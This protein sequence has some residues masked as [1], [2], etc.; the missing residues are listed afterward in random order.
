MKTNR[1]PPL[2]CSLLV[3]ALAA[4]LAARGKALLLDFGPTATQAAYAT[5]DPAHWLGAVPAS[6]ITWNTTTRDTNTVYYSDGATATGLSLELGRSAAGVDIINFSDNGF[7]SSALG[8]SQN[9]GVYAGSSPVRDAIF[10]GSGGANN[11]AVGLRVNGLPAGTYTLFVHGRNTSTA[12]A[13]PLLFYA[14]NRASAD[15]YTFSINDVLAALSN[16]SPAITNGFNE[17]NNYGVLTVSLAAGESLYI[18]SEGTVSGEARGF[19]NAIVIYFGVPQLPARVTSQPLNKSVYEGVTMTFNAGV[20]GNPKP[21]YQWHFNGTDTLVDGPGIS[22]ATTDKLTLHKVTPAMAGDYSLAVTNALGW[23]ASSNATLMVSSPFNTAQMTNTW[24]LLPGERPYLGIGGTERSMAY[25]P[26]NGNL[27]L[28]SRAAADPSIVVLDG[29]NGAEKHLMNV[30][31]IPSTTPNASVGLSTIGVADDGVVFG[32][33]V[34]VGATTAA[35]NIYG[36]PDDTADYQPSLVFAGDPAASVQPNLRWGDNFAVRGAGADTQILMAPTTGTNVALLRTTSGQNFQ[37][38]IPPAIIAV[39][40]VPSGFARWSIAFGPGTNTFWAKTSGGALFLVEFNV[41]AGTGIVTHSYSA[42]LMPT[43]IRAIGVDPAGKFLGGVMSDPLG[44]N[45]RLFEI[46][47]LG[48]SPVIRDQEVFETQ[49]AATLGSAWVAFGTNKVF[50]LDENNGIKAFAIDPNY[51]PPSVSILAQPVDRTAMEGAT[52]TFTALVSGL[53]PLTM[54]WRLNETNNLADSAYISGAHTNV[55][56]LRGI[57]LESAGS[58]SLF[59][60]NLYGMATSSNAVL[61]VVPTF[62]TPQMTNI[63]NLLAEE[64]SYLGT[65]NTE[66]GLAYNATTT[67]LLLVSRAPHDPAVVVLNAETGVEKR[68]LDVTGIPGSVANVSLGLNTIGVADDGVVYGAS[69]AVNPTTTPFY[70]YRWPNDQAGIAPAVVFN[71]DPSGSVQPGQRWGDVMAVRGSGSGTQVLM[72]P[73]SGTNVVILR[74]ANGSD[75]QNEIPPAVI[76][77]SG[78]PSG[79]SRLGIAFGPGQTRSGR[80]ARAALCTLSSLTSI[81]NWELCCMSIPPTR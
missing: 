58:Y 60:E 32:A 74:T 50:A 11:L 34:T 61:T 13:A 47:D 40:G 16:T 1:L 51:I 17:G 36:W 31:G 55:L 29:S 64:H 52:V 78:V 33:G 79:F 21:V 42:P 53:D 67:N 6:E 70:L 24:N 2:A 46:S 75:F 19:M 5:N 9:T 72:A 18:A 25:N 14:T 73:A 57:T 69:V 63:W 43:G 8:G 38:E 76:A 3:L 81:P 45:F 27:L 59:V 44:N 48:A 22:G 77:V 39:S 30:T 35:L 54:Q 20:S 37:T 4:P 65:N 62:N 10:G 80:K 23:E 12:T 68:F 71:G 49:N 15:T 41:D 7:S 26:V 56:T 66:R 28:V